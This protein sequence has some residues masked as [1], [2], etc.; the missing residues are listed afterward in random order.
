M[1]AMKTTDAV[2]LERGAKEFRAIVIDGERPPAFRAMIGS[3]EAAEGAHVLSAENPINALHIR[4]LALR[5][6]NRLHHGDEDERIRIVV[7]DGAE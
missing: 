7:A 6:K 3:F 4:M 5:L 2:R 1:V